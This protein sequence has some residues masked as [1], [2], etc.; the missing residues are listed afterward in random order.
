[1]DSAPSEP[2]SDTATRRAPARDDAAL[3]IHLKTADPAESNSTVGGDPA[4]KEDSKPTLSPRG[5]T[6]EL[7]N[8]TQRSPASSLR[9]NKV[10]ARPRLQSSATIALSLADVNSQLH[11][12]GSQRTRSLRSSPSRMSLANHTPRRRSGMVPSASSMILRVY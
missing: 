1:M 11:S 6:L 2:S 5:T 9:I 10:I 7:M 8:A 12:D 4:F 3:P